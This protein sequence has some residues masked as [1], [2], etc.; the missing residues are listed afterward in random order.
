MPTVA[1]APLSG[2]G[3]ILGTAGIDPGPSGGGLVSVAPPAEVLGHGGGAGSVSLPAFTMGGA[4]TVGN[5][6]AGNVSFGDSEVEEIG[7]AHV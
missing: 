4:G 1:A 6:G 7:R 2:Q 5:L 3:A